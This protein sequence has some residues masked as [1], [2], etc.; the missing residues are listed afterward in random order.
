MEGQLNIVQVGQRICLGVVHKHAVGKS[1]QKAIAGDPVG[2]EDVY[3]LNQINV[4]VK[5]F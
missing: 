5:S 1:L 2:K 4:E 3:I